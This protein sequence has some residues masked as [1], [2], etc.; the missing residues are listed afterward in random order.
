MSRPAIDT[1]A[2][3]VCHAIRDVRGESEA[4]I[5]LDRLVGRPGLESATAVDAAAAFAAAKGWL[6]I[7]RAAK[8]SVLLSH[9][10]P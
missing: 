4:W 3:R 1:L 10:A 8:H 7:D 6:A 5:G 2:V 9:R